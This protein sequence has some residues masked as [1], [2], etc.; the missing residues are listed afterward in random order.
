MDNKIRTWLCD[1]LHSIEEIESYFEN[2]PQDFLEYQKDTK[3]KRVFNAF[4]FLTNDIQRNGFMQYC[5]LLQSDEQWTEGQ[6]IL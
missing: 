4:E 3:T 5:F 6:R 2:K 1:I